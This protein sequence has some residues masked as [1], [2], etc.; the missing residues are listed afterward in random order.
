MSLSMTIPSYYADLAAQNGG[1]YLQ[2]NANGNSGYELQINDNLTLAGASAADDLGGA[3]AA[4]NAGTEVAGGVGVGY[5]KDIRTVGTA[6]AGLYDLRISGVTNPVQVI[7][8]KEYNGYKYAVK[9]MVVS[10]GDG[11]IENLLLPG[12][13]GEYS[14]EVNAL[15]AASGMNTGYSIEL[16][17]VAAGENMAISNI[18]TL[19]GDNI[20]ID[21]ANGTAYFYSKVSEAGGAYNFNFSGTITGTAVMNVYEMLAN[22]TQ[23][24]VRQLVL[25]NYIAEAKS[26]SIFLDDSANVFSTGIY[27]FEVISYGGKGTVN[28]GCSGY[29]VTN[30]IAN[31]DVA[32]EFGVRDWVGKGDAEE[33]FP[34]AARAFYAERYG[35]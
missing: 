23:R 31:K 13:N 22:G 7:V 24:F 17:R 34:G 33:L 19:I 14:I 25:N 26:G 28:I 18:N 11:V 4:L 27:K 30:Y 35:V 9:S 6:E 5:Q 8:Y 1:F 15:Y 32:F 29:D 20:G 12:N 3:L 16:E 2:V 21:L 10:A